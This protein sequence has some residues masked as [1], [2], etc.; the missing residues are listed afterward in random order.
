MLFYNCKKQLTVPL[1]ETM[2]VPIKDPKRRP[3]DMVN[4]MAGI[5]RIWDNIKYVKSVST[6]GYTLIIIQKHKKATAK[7]YYDTVENQRLKRVNKDVG[8]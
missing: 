7:N 5:A 8:V 2:I 3:A 6:I 1:I 4:G